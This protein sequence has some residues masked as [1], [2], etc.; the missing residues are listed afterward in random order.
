MAALWLFIVL[1]L[2]VLV[3]WEYKRALKRCPDVR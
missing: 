3:Y 1:S 2:S